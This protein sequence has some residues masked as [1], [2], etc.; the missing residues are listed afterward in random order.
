VVAI[1]REDLALRVALLDLNRQECFLDLP[2]ERLLVR[3]EQI[4]RQ[5]LRQRA[6]AGALPANHV[7]DRGDDDA[8][9]AEAE[10]GVEAL[11]LGGDDGLTQQR[12]DLV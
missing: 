3:E 2:V 6:R 5:L 9:K 12:R 11:I 8:R 10:V 1:E 4:A 7:L